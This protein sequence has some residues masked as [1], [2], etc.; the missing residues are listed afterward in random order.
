MSDQ[1]DPMNYATEVDMTKTFAENFRT[2]EKDFPR[3]A[4]VTLDNVNSD[5]ST[6]TAYNKDCY[7]INSSENCENCSYGKLLQQS[8]NCFDSSYIYTS[9]WLYQCFN[10]D[11]CSHCI[12]NYNSSSCSNCQFSDDCVGCHYCFLCTGLRNKQYYIRNQ[13]YTKEQR[14]EEMQKYNRDYATFQQHRTSF[15]EIRKEMIVQT[16]HQKNCEKSYGDYLLN[17]KKCIFCY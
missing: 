4:T 14:Q 15:E 9:E 17:N 10:V 6:G 3:T 8:N 7:L 12:Y 5:Y 16:M 13:Q 2:L 1:L 11:N